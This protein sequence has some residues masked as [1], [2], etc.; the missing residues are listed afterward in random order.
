MAKIFE[1]HGYYVDPNDDY[2]AEELEILLSEKFDIMSHH[3]K[4]DER[5]IGEWED[6]NPLN[7]TDCHISEC[8]R[9][10]TDGNSNICSSVFN[11]LNYSDYVEIEYEGKKYVGRIK[12][13]D[14]VWIESRKRNGK[15]VYD[16]SF[17]VVSLIQKDTNC[18][19]SNIILKHFS[20]IKV[21]KGE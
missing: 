2:D 17:Y 21:Y 20:D 3:I 14:S 16:L 15:V 9:Y 1:F 4:V 13:V 8:M 7:Y 19:I 6:E 18:I 10:F 12:S 5:D 11:M